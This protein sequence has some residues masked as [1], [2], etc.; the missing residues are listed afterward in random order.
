[1]NSTQSSIM[2]HIA[3]KVLKFFLRSKSS[4]FLG[5]ELVIKINSQ[6]SIWSS[7]P[8]DI[9]YL[10]CLEKSITY[11]VRI[12]VIGNF[13][14][15]ASRAPILEIKSTFTSVNLQVLGIPQNLRPAVFWILY[16]RS[17]EV[18]SPTREVS[19]QP[20]HVCPCLS[21][22]WNIRHY[23][24]TFNNDFCD[25]KKVFTHAQVRTRRFFPQCPINITF[26]TLK[27]DAFF[28]VHS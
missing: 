3:T 12:I 18:H 1:M 11:Y 7:H 24:N 15:N 26:G 17:R 28:V 13:S 5:K 22:S 6:I 23:K 16:Y 14:L 2:R 10:I 9:W 20:S 25:K 8:G 19:Q 4:V 21:H 27:P